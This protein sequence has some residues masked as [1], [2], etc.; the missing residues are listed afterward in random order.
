MAIF[1]TKDYTANKSD[2]IRVAVTSRLHM[3]VPAVNADVDAYIES[4]LKVLVHEEEKRASRV[5]AEQAVQ[6]DL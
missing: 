2:R 6:D 1:K 3:Q 4:H 5:A